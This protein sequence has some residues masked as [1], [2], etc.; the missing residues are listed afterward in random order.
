MAV[1]KHFFWRKNDTFVCAGMSCQYLETNGGAV[2]LTK[3]HN[4]LKKKLSAMIYRRISGANFLCFLCFFVFFCV[5]FFLFQTFSSWAACRLYLSTM[6]S[7]CCLKRWITSLI[8]RPITNSTSNWRKCALLCLLP[9]KNTK[10]LRW[11]TNAKGLA[12]TSFPN[13]PSM[14]WRKVLPCRTLLC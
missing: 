5:C 4:S 7:L 6:K 10:L 9:K 2:S 8:T 1:L 11:R 3:K 12:R 14:L 13:W